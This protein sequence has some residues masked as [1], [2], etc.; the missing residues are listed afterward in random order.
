MSA[1]G[2]CR[3][4]TAKIT[5]RV[6]KFTKE[7]FALRDMTHLLSYKPSIGFA[8]FISV[9]SKRG[10][11]NIARILVEDCTCTIVANS[12]WDPHR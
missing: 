12:L 3:P 4:T 8:E 2:E 7:F 9:Q 5:V 11:E 10:M 6:I 1:T